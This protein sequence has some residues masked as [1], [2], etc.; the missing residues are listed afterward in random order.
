MPCWNGKTRGGSFGYGFFIFL[1]KHLGLN[2]AYAFLFVVVPYFVPFAPKATAASWKYW[3][4]IHN[5]SVL[6]AIGKIFQHYYRFG[7]VII[8]KIAASSGLEKEFSF[9]F[10]GMDCLIDHLKRGEK[11][12]VMIGAHVGNWEVSRVFMKEYG[13]KLNVVMLDAEYQKIKDKLESTMGANT[14]GVI[15]VST[16]NIDHIFKIQSALA[17]NEVVCF[18]GDRYIR[19]E[20]AKTVQFLGHDAPFPPGPHQIATMTGADTFFFFAVRESGKKYRFICRKAEA[21]AQ[22][23]N[24][25]MKT[26]ASM[27]EYIDFLETIVRQYPEQWFNFYDFW[28]M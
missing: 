16:E 27:Q 7:Q 13:T 18:Q 19:E 21:A 14:F 9:L 5:K 25:K 17:T 20:D 24:R 12:A 2:A 11:G 10:D 4:K 6:C 8:D 26:S 23:T 22:E 28:R 1:I 3:R 15:P